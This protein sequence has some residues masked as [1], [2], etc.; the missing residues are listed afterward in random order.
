M[1]GGQI[2]QQRGC[3]KY[4]MLAD[5]S[6][7]VFQFNLPDGKQQ[8][9]TMAGSI[10]T[11]IFTV[12]TLIFAISQFIVLSERSDYHI[13]QKE[14]KGALTPDK[15]IYESKDGFAIAAG[16]WGKHGTKIDPDYASLKFL[17]KSWDSSTDQVKFRE[18]DQREC[19]KEDFLHPGDE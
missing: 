19:L 18:I 5:L 8:F 14:Q 15:F 3:T 6:Q 4:L 11:L 17:I 1:E 16:F 12:I 9:K 13:T 7:H 10:T 2:Y